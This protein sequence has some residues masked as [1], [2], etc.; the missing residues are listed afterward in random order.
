MNLTGQLLIGHDER[1]GAG[2][3]F[4]AIDPATGATLAPAFCSASS[5][6]VERAARLAECAFDAYRS[7]TSGQRARFLEAIADGI[8]ALGAQLIERAMQET[9][10]PRARLEGERGRTTGQL[11]LFARELR[12]GGWM[13]ATIDP[14]QPE[15]QPMRRPDLRMHRIAVGPVAVFGASNFPLAFS[16]AG[17]DTASALAAGCPV[18]VKAHPSHP[19]TSELVARVIARAV[20]E[21]GMP[22]GTFS[23]V[24]GTG[25]DVGIALVRHPAV[26]AVAFTGSRAGG[27][28][29]CRTAGER[30]QPIPVFAEMSAINPVFLMPGALHARAERIAAGYVEAL[31][32][33]TGQL[34]TN[35]GIVLGVASPGWDRF[36][37]GVA[38]ALSGRAA[39][40]MLSPD[41]HRAFRDGTQRMA[42]TPGVACVARGSAGEG[43]CSAEAVVCQT[44]AAHFMTQPSLHDEVFGP[45]GL[46]VRCDDVAQMQA[47]AQAFEGQLTATLHIDGDD[48]AAAR[49]LVPVLERKAGRL[50]V[51]GFPAGV[52]V[53]H[54]MVHGGPFPA[55]SDTRT[56]S[57]GVSA[58]ERFL[59]PVCYQ[60]FP[61]ELLPEA[62]M[63]DNPAGIPQRVEGVFGQHTS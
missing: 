53:C 8:E 49:A 17:G 37:A 18:I 46:L 55:T 7:T 41:I 51:N 14:A 39:G 62:L 58:M 11:R 23:M 59:R 45:A 24:A 15:R 48:V 9:G 12:A 35:P 47:L 32:M 42:N 28:A 16:V 26:Q 54:A 36:V 38:A 52:E 40:T 30:P 50:I 63:P 31:V 57:V 20:R 60:D 1:G 2:P 29:L 22:E 27:L 61:P 13:R 56:T 10:L 19:G 5:D 21:Q 25:H 33:G 43:A 3:G 6:D 34:C 44:T 4:H